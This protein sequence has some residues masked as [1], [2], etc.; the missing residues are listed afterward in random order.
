MEK[1]RRREHCSRIELVL[2][3][4]RREK[5]TAKNKDSI[6]GRRGK[7]VHV[8]TCIHVRHFPDLPGGEITIEFTS[9]LKH[10]TTATKK[11]SPRMKMGWKKKRG[12]HCSKIELVLP[13]KEEGK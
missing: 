3:E 7:S 6:L 5:E 9:T 8:R 1:K 10:C 2:P 4:R 11:N 12:E 13:Q